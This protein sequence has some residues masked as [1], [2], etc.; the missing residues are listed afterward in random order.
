[1]L[2]ISTADADDLL[3]ELLNEGV[4]CFAEPEALGEISAEA[5]E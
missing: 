1:M 5:A 3:F 4:L 2:G